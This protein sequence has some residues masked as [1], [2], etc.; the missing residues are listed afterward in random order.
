M[1]IVDSC[2]F[3]MS[4]HQKITYKHQT[5]LQIVDFA[6][7]E[8]TFDSLNEGLPIYMAKKKSGFNL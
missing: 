5:A 3:T 7:Q 8:R 2:I 4:I 6:S 1:Y